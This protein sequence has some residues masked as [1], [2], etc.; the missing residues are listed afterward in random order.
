MTGK[1]AGGRGGGE[2]F[3]SRLQWYNDAT[4]MLYC[5]TS[6]SQIIVWGVVGNSRSGTLVPD[7]GLQA[8]PVGVWKRS[9]KLKLQ[10][11]PLYRNSFPRTPPAIQ[12]SRV[13]IIGIPQAPFIYEARSLPG[14][15]I[16]VE[17]GT[18]EAGTVSSTDMFWFEISIRHSVTLLQTNF[19]FRVMD[20]EDGKTVTL[21]LTGFVRS[22][23]V[24][25]E[26]AYNVTA[27]CR[28]VFGVSAESNQV[29]VSVQLTTGM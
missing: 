3:G 20:Y 23:D 18:A 7:I 12:G 10:S 29:S 15:Q 28:N 27:S 17:L 21:V 1:K 6:T 25:E 11:V 26:E 22:E 4:T 19:T 8:C 2:N 9:Y 14:G 24:G 16:S 13:L 5:Q